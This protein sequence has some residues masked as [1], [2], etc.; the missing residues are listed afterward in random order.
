MR[1]PAYSPLV[2]RHFDRPLHAGPLRGDAEN[3][4]TGSAGQ[5]ERGTEVRFEARIEGGRI[6]AI[7]FQAYGCPHTIAACSLAC[8][9]L[10]GQPAAA[11]GRFDPDELGAALEVPP[12]KT[13]RLLLVQDALHHCFRAWEN[14]G[15]AGE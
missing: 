8:E 14:R 15:L 12:G 11:L 4:V 6:A 2:T 13:G 10:D 1:D 5:R 3:V 7:A 9:R